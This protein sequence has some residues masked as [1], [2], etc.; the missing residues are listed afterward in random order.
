MVPRRDPNLLS[1]YLCRFCG[2]RVAWGGILRVL[3]V[4]PDTPGFMLNESYCHTD[5]LRAVVR[6][7]VE[8]TFHRHWA[9][10]A[11]MPDDSADIDGQPCAICAGTIAPP[12][13][14]RLRLQRPAGT[15]KR[16]EFDEQS[17][18]FHFECLAQVS[19]SRLS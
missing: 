9:G 7:G 19:R 3:R 10:R 8:L 12:D 1:Q 11:P 5:C 13:L 6:P 14:V 4:D 2:E 15:V 16:P 18:P 17:L